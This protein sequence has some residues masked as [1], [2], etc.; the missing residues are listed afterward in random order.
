MNKVYRIVLFVAFLALVST[1]PVPEI[2][3]YSESKPPGSHKSKSEPGPGQGAAV[4]QTGANSEKDSD[5]KQRVIGI[6]VSHYQGT[7]DWDKVIAHPDTKFV[8]LKATAGETYTDPKYHQN[9]A[10]IQDTKLLT[11]AYHF[12]EPNDEGDAQAKNF[13]STV[14]Y[15]DHSL[16]PVLDIEITKSVDPATIRKRA[17]KFLEIVQQTTGCK[18][19]IY[20]YKDYWIT[21]LGSEFSDYHLWLADY[22]TSPS[23][24]ENVENWL[25]WQFTQSGT[26]PGIRGHVDL[27]HFNGGVELMQKISCS[28]RVE[29]G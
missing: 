22:A 5:R 26:N 23:L 28:N 20:T 4:A 12:F 25:L 29:R 8:Y 3:H 9:I 6:D 16:P 15:S 27:S 19:I 1:L 17:R 11:G 18:P 10:S 24:P 14:R 13:L 2:H 7:I 21:N